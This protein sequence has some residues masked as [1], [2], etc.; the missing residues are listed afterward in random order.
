MHADLEEPRTPES[1]VLVAIM[2]VLPRRDRV[3]EGAPSGDAL[4]PALQRLLQR[5]G[6]ARC[7][8]EAQRGDE[9]ELSVQRSRLGSSS[10]DG[11]HLSKSRPSQ[12]SFTA[13]YTRALPF[14]LSCPRKKSNKLQRHALHLPNQERRGCLTTHNTRSVQNE[15]HS[16]RI[17]LPSQA[18]RMAPPLKKLPGLRHLVFRASHL[19]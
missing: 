2:R 3:H 15:S 16:T 8:S 11:A 9:G 14:E 19:D 12:I 6:A 5:C 4:L 18:N 1:H 7:S 13:Q 10:G 17:C